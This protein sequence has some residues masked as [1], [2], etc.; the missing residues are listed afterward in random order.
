MGCG[1]RRRGSYDRKRTEGA[2]G[3]TRQTGRGTVLSKRERSLWRSFATGMVHAIGESM[4]RE[5][6]KQASKRIGMHLQLSDIVALFH[7]RQAEAAKILGISLSAMKNACRRVGITRWPYSRSRPN[8]PDDEVLA[9][10]QETANQGNLE[11]YTPSDLVMRTE[12]GVSS[13]STESTVFEATQLFDAF[14]ED[15]PSQQSS[16]SIHSDREDDNQAEDSRN[17]T[18]SQSYT[19]SLDANAEA[20][21]VRRDIRVPGP[22][23][24]HIGEKEEDFPPLNESWIRN[25]IQTI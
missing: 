1:I 2:S 16:S 4:S 14:L 22:L 19:P 11:S 9:E 6:E 8:L 13:E 23:C 10:N 15:G 21:T 7:L 25:F 17:Y 18:Q 3:S 24:R 12:D 5:T 20:E